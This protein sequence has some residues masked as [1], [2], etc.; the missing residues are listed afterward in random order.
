MIIA[1]INAMI[2]IYYY[3]KVVIAM[4]M[5]ENAAASAICVQPGYRWVL[6]VVVILLFL[7]GIF[8]GLIT[9]IL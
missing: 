1:V 9:D 8:P 3:F 7:F 5:K 6:S 4:Y 2:G